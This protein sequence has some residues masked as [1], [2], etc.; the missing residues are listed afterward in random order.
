MGRAGLTSLVRLLF[1]TSLRHNNFQVTDWVLAW[2]GN[3]HQASTIGTG[4]GRWF[5]PDG[6]VAGRIVIAAVEE[7]LF[8]ARFAFNQISST[9]GTEGTGLI[10]NGAPIAAL[11][12]A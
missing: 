5:L 1:I 8:L 10:D 7:A 9:V 2:L 12:K 6:E 11:R 4:I 3:D